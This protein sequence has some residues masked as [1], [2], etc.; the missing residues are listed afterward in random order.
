MANKIT[1]QSDTN[2]FPV[3][4]N[5]R[6]IKIGGKSTS[7]ELAQSDDGA[8]IRGDLIVEGGGVHLKTGDL[9]V[10]GN[11]ISGR[12]VSAN[13]LDVTYINNFGSNDLVITESNDITLDAANDIILDAANVVTLD[14]AD[15]NA[16]QG[17][18][19]KMAGTQVGDITG[20]HSET[21][22]TL[23]ENVGASTND[24]FQIG[25]GV[26]G[27]TD[28]QTADAT[29]AS[30]HLKIH[31]D[32]DT[33][34]DRDV[35]LTTA[36]TYAG[37]YIDYDK[38]GT[39]TSDNTLYGL[40]IDMD[41]TTATNGTNIMYGIYC[42]PTL[43]HAADAGAATVVGGHFLATG[44][45]NGT[46][47]SVGVRIDTS[48]S[49]GATAY[50]L[51]IRSND[52]TDDFFAIALGSEAATTIST[53]SDGGVL[54]PLTLDI[55][56]D[57]NFD[58]ASG[59][60]YFLMNGETDDYGRI[61]VTTGTGAKNIETVSAGDD[62][63]ITLDPDG[64]LRLTPTTEVTSD[65]PLKIKEASNAVADTAAY[66]QL[67]VKTATP[68]E[69]YFT[70]DAGDDVQLT[71][72]TSTAGGGGTVY[73]MP[74]FSGRFYTRY[75]DWY[76]P[77]ASYGATYFNWSGSSASATMPSALNDAW[78]P[79]I[80]V[81]KDCTLTDY[82][83]QGNFTSAHTYELALLKGVKA[84][85][86]G[87]AGD[88]ALAQIGA[89]QSQAA[90]AH[91]QYK[92]GQTGLSVSLSAGD[93]LFPTIRRTTTDTSAVYYFEQVFSIIAEVS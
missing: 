54:A 82:I 51:Q 30:A 1:L 64:E 48:A 17:I 90:T 65:V 74:Q 21:F 44:H 29:G 5:L 75:D 60:Y 85:G 68:N 81:P 46:G 79:M 35:N 57:I 61:I 37:L 28:I 55:D 47:T 43:Q 70:T 62:G 84:N 27:A 41:N 11:I 19:F 26:S 13:T 14:A 66:G 59:R 40:N 80:I 73:W 72:G 2:P 33:T 34:I 15:V 52:D 7:L 20:H 92:L 4:E 36:G 38:T 77:S 87:A 49:L 23:Y 45:T 25:V 71:S 58:A 12:T 3:D 76:F 42:T 9:S 63:H 91:W 31:A 24:Y 93:V 16:F 69:L 86:F 88:Y 10:K 18:Q 22:F 89:T 39:S 53:Y 56:G 32:G 8:R 6:P 83:Y 67:W 50:G 78:N